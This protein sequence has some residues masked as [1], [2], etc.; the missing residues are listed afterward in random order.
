[1]DRFEKRAKQLVSQMT[2]EEKLGMLS[3]HQNAVER[4]GLPEFY[5]GTEVAR[6]Y[7]GREPE[8]ISTVFPQP[9]GL[10]ATFDRELM[11]DLGVIAGKEAR[12]YYSIGKKGGLMLWGPTVDMERDPRWGRTEE[13]YGE[14]VFLAG[15]LTAQYTSGMAGITDDGYYMT[16]PTL[17]HFCANNNE[18]DR[19]NCDAFLPPRLKHEYYYAA[20]ANAVRRGGARSVMTAYNEINGLPA[21]MNPDLEDVL[22]DE[23]GL[24]FT[25][26]DGGDMSQNVTL[27]RYCDSMAEAFALSLKGGCDV[28]TDGEELV[29]EAAKKALGRGLVTWDDIDRSITRTVAARLR[30]GQLTENDPF[31]SIDKSVIDCEEHRETNFRA[32]L[33][34]VVMLKN[35]GLLPVKNAPEKIAVVGCLADENLRDWYTGYF[36]DAVSVYEGIKREF[37]DSEVVRDKLWDIVAVKAPNGMYLSVRDDGS[38]AA[39]ADSIGD[40]EKFELQ[41]WGDNWNNLYSVKYGKYL[42]MDEDTLKLHNEVVYD[43]FTRETFNIYEYADSCI[44]EDFQ[45]HKRLTLAGN[46]GLT[47]EKQ[48]AATADNRFEIEYVS[49]GHDRAKK[50]SEENDLVVYCTGNHPV[51]TAKECYDRRTLTLE[52]EVRLHDCSNAVMVLISSYP[53]S[54]STADKEYPAILYTT[55]AGAHLGTAVAQT[56]SGKNNPSGHLPLTWY[57]SEHDLPDIHEYDIEKAGTTYMY[58]A[59]TPLYPFGHGISYSEFELGE[60]RIKRAES[61]YSV[62]VAVTNKSGTDGTA[63]VQIYRLSDGGESVITLPKKKLCGF[64]RVTVK[65]GET[66]TAV[67]AVPEHILRVYDVRSGRM[68]VEQGTYTFAAGLSSTDIRVS[69][70]LFIEGETVGKRPAAF[71]ADSFEDHDDIRICHSRS[72]RRFYVRACGW[73]GRL[74]YG[75][76][77]TFRVGAVKLWISSLNGGKVTVQIGDG[78]YE[79]DVPVCDAC[80]DF[81]EITVPTEN[82]GDHDD[83]IIIMKEGMCLLDIEISER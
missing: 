53:Y 79:A 40:A 77:G 22:K 83:L 26:S 47:F 63:T 52:S 60:L 58:F 76:I 68:I 33:E 78:K 43:W 56:L 39:D 8:K 50:L 57:R 13:A 73:T 75:G 42:R 21:I 37:P 70:T 20:F 35:D 6:G 69:D 71:S 54:I 29:R 18:N 5:I 72:L 32:A 17:K 28:M 3:T 30:L 45:F 2:E 12:A 24:W 66:V 74:V 34:Q 19:G 49:Y 48:C 10:A 27:H 55:H 7:V 61:G 81:A 59:G 38:V 51:Q 41:S 67:I 4:L 36:T 44:I 1:M 16:V 25:V 65:A 15:E 46:G 82:C 9:V 14:D 11:Y 80:D 31:G 62:S 64:D 23:W